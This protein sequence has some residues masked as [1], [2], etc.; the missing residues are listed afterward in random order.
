MAPKHR[1]AAYRDPLSGPAATRPNWSAKPASNGYRNEL[2]L[3]SSF[4]RFVLLKPSCVGTSHCCRYR[5]PRGSITWQAHES[6]QHKDPRR[7]ACRA[8]VALISE[9]I[10]QIR[11][12]GRANCARVGWALS[13]RGIRTSR[14]Q[15]ISISSPLSQSLIARLSWKR[16]CSSSMDGSDDGLW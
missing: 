9:K 1:C 8:R 5:G 6:Q 13:L 4:E 3:Q 10:E 16:P 12:P 15:T 11:D 7:Y 2:M 14:Q